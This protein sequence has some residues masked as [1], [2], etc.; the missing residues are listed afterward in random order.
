[1]SP[2][3]KAQNIKHEKQHETSKN[4]N[5][6]SHTRQINYFEIKQISHIYNEL[7]QTDTLKPLLYLLKD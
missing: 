1:M 2:K 5:I 3:R 7:L 6:C 4:N